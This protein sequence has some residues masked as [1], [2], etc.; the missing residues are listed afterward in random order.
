MT[1]SDAQEWGLQDDS[2]LR[3]LVTQCASGR[4]VLFVGA[5]LSLACVDAAGR[6]GPTG[7]ELAEELAQQFLAE[8]ASNRPLSLIVEFSLTNASKSDIDSAIAERLGDLQPTEAIKRLPIIPWRSL[9]TTNF[10][11]VLEQAYSS[12]ENPSRNV[13]TIYSSQTNLAQLGPEEIPLYKVHGSIDRL[14]SSEGRLALTSEDLAR[15]RREQGKIFQRLADEIGEYT[16]LYLGYGREDQTFH[17]LL[18]EVVDAAGGVDGLRRSFAL[19][20]GFKEYERARWER[21]KISLVN[22][23]AE[24]FLPWLASEV[25]TLLEE[26]SVREEAIPSLLPQG[27]SLPSALVAPF[28]RSYEVIAEEMA[29]GSAGPEGF[30]KGDRLTWGQLSAD[31]D[32]RR[33]ITDDVVEVV[34]DEQSESG[35]RTI[36][37]LGEAGA[38]KTTILRRIGADLAAVWKLPTITLRDSALLSYREVEPLRTVLDNRL[39]ILIDNAADHVREI[40]DFVREARSARADVTLILAARNNEWT[41]RVRQTEVSPDGVFQLEYL[42]EPEIDRVIDRLTHFR[43]LGHL[44]TLSPLERKSAFRDNAER[45]LLVALREATEG[46][47]FEE[48]IIDEFSSISSSEA[49][50]AYLFVCCVYRVGVALR[51]GILRRLTGVPFEEFQEKLLAPAERVLI[52]ERLPDDLEYRARHPIIAEIVSNHL[53]PT[54]ENLL[55]AYLRIMELLDIGSTDVVSF[56]KISRNRALVDSLTRYDLRAKFYKA[57]RET[58]PDDSIV[59]QHWAIAAMGAGRFVTARQQLAEARKLAPRDNAIQHTAG[60]LALTQY[61]N[62]HRGDAWER[63]HFNTAEKEFLV[64]TKRAKWDAHAYDSLADL[65]EERARRSESGERIV[66]YGRAQEVLAD[67]IDQAEDKSGLIAADAGIHERLG[68]ME[69]ADQDFQ[70]ALRADARNSHARILYSRYL[71]RSGR[72][73]DSELQLD[74]GLSL[75]KDDRRLRQAYAEVLAARGRARDEVEA[76]Y[77]LATGHQYQNWNAAFEFA[78]YLFWTSREEEAANIFRTLEERGFDQRELR[79]VRRRPLF[80]QN[81]EKISGSVVLLRDTFGFIR[82]TNHS[83]DIYFNRYYLEDDTDMRL[84]NGVEVEFEMGFTLRGPRATNIRIRD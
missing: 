56:R 15:A 68:E 43:E 50:N 67:G 79:R 51:A 37:L 58:A 65:Y 20:P 6:H 12:A 13:R 31:Y 14:D 26:A 9:F 44:E 75:D 48:I 80:W 24:H 74:E 69:D 23:Q 78:V 59:A 36:L 71:Q 49:R 47:R 2:Q 25:Q 41:D 7:P 28:R 1:S 40:A 11:T 30:F 10:D 66:W 73:G 29:S 81:A 32:A 21:S 82:R 38:G 63:V 18:G 8:S 39:H 53:L 60:M 16:V 64:L 76:Q 19:S 83:V 33:D 54:P 72:Y 61:R 46:R 52:E 3:Y 77:R 22:A 57:C 27:E 4:C 55:D 5:G 84:T 42:S 45:Q 70:A 35:V 34:L 17:E 62:T